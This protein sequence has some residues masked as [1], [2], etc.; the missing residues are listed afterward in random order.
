M[1][2]LI[3]L[4]IIA[5]PLLEVAI[6]IEVARGIGILPAIAGAVIAGIAGLALWRQQGL[7]TLWRRAKPWSAAVCRWPRC[8]TGC[9]WRW[10]ACCC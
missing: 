10:P 3:I 7:Q 6:F 9:A 8:S 5:L 4:A 1:A 2:W